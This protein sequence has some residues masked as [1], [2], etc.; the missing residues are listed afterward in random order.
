MLVPQCP[1]FSLSNCVGISEESSDSESEEDLECLEDFA[2]PD[3]GIIIMSS[4]PSIDIAVP[5][6]V[7]HSGTSKSHSSEVGVT[8]LPKD[9]ESKPELIPDYMKCC[10]GSQDEL[11]KC[12]IALQVSGLHISPVEISRCPLILARRLYSTTKMPGQRR[13][14]RQAG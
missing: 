8:G 4:C 5:S 12:C 2:S 10:T 7:N 3:E 14:W 1:P 9:L 11:Q 13:W 6:E